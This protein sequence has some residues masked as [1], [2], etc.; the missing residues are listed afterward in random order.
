MMV[1]NIL[2]PGSYLGGI[3]LTNTLNNMIMRKTATA[4]TM[5]LGLL[6]FLILLG[7]MRVSDNICYTN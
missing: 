2:S 1:F 7:I 3:L 4:E 6:G 5:G